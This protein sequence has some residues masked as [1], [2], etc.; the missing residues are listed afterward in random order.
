M[1]GR[2]RLELFLFVGELTAL[3]RYLDYEMKSGQSIQTF[4][5]NGPMFGAT[6]RW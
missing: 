6:F 3:W 1:A 5:F 4:N 2:Y